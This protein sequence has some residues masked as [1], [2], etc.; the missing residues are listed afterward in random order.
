MR[1]ISG[2][3]RGRAN[4]CDFG[5][6]YCRE[7]ERCHRTI[8]G[9]GRRDPCSWCDFALLFG[10]VA[11]DEA[12][13]TSDLDLLIAYDLPQLKVTILSFRSTKQGD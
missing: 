8:E 6:D 13:D 11:R 3:K 10:S 12:K 1:M 5:L 7:E 4:E 9:E 2:K